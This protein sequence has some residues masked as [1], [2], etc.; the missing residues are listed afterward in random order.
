[1]KRLS[2]IICHLS[3][4]VALALCLAS[5]SGNGGNTYTLKGTAAFMTDGQLELLDDQGQP[6]DTIDVKNGQFSY[7]GQADSACL[8]TLSAIGWENGVGTAQFFTEPGTITATLTEVPQ[9]STIGGTTANDALQ[10]L[11][12]TTNPLY[13]KINELETLVYTDTAQTYDQ[14]ALAGKYQQLV[15]EI[16]DKCKEFAGANIDNELG[17]MLVIR[18]IDPSEDA[19][20]LRSLIAKMPEKFR[21]RQQTKELEARLQA[22]EATGIG[23]TIADFSLNTPQ[24]EPL[25]VMSEVKKNKLTIL[26]FWASWCGP[27]RREMPFMKELYAKYQSKGLG[28]VGISLDE[29]ASEW[30]RA[31]EELKIPWPQM[32]DLRGWECSAAQTFQ[33]NAIPYLI[34][35]DQEG[36]ILQK[37]LRGEELEQF[38][39]QQLQ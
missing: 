24:G 18:F 31:I 19:A 4:S 11:A 1:M 38:V 23:Q 33:V 3:F 22:F 29:S 12:E 14:L 2:S 35:L 34:V 28:I 6:L 8:Y 27:C 20:L 16:A 36:K 13:D 9:Q 25:S 5:C 39:A 37:G 26:D 30:N 10:K 7:T 21:Q 17:F 32:S 15:N